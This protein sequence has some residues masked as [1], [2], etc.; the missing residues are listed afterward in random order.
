MSE[1][2]PFILK[3]IFSFRCPGCRQH[4]MFVG[5]T[6]DFNNLGKVYTLCPNCGTDL[7]IE[8]GFYWG[9]IYLAWGFSA[10]FALV[11]FLLYHNV[12]GFSFRT[13]VTLFVVVQLLI[14]PYIYR[15]SKSV[16]VHIVVRYK[17]ERNY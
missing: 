16:W 13:T 11:Q 6:F 8:P 17:G 7:Y 1:F 5:K 9:A 3:S 10:M 14:S 15:L 4:S 2:K 12:F